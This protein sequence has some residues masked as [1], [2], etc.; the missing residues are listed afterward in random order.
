VSIRAA[1]SSCWSDRLTAPPRRFSSAAKR[2][3]SSVHQ[4]ET[5]S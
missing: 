1:T 2:N 5:A 4:L 3:E